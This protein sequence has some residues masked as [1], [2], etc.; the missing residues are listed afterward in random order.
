MQN[1]LSINM[2]ANK[3]SNYDDIVRFP[4][5][6]K[7]KSNHDIN[8]YIDEQNKTLRAMGYTEHKYAHVEIV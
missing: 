2:N 8:V 4:L 7:V 5:F 1:D 3:F 6:N